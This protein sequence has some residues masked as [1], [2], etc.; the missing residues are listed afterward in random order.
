MKNGATPLL[1]L[2]RFFFWELSIQF[3]CLLRYETSSSKAAYH[4]FP[5]MHENSFI[6]LL[7]LSPKS[8]ATFREPRRFV[9]TVLPECS[10]CPRQA[11]LF[12]LLSEREV[13]AKSYPNHPVI[14]L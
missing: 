8:L 9:F 4:S 5:C 6:P 13:I 10:S 2:H 11:A 14:Q 1:M 12:R 7:L 3:P